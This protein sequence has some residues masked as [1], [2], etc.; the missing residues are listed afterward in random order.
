MCHR[1]QIKLNKYGSDFEFLM[2]E[3]EQLILSKNDFFI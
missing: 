1:K 2:F 3:R